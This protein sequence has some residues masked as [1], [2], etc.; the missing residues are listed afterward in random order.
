MGSVIGPNEVHLHDSALA[1]IPEGLPKGFQQTLTAAHHQDWVRAIRTGSQTVDG[2]ESAFRSD[3]ISQLSDLCI[4]TGAPV[5]WD[6]AKE[7]VIGNEMARM[8]MR[9]A[10]RSPWGVG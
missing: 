2:I 5:R 7:T 4:R 1:T 3:L 6:P 10:M 8:M 9:R